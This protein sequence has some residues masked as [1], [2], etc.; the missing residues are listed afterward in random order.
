M[1]PHCFVECACV[2]GSQPV[3]LDPLRLIMVGPFSAT[4]LNNLGFHPRE[5]AH[6]CL[7]RKAAKSEFPARRSVEA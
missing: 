5:L 2:F 7:S 6:A 4:A 1:A 3:A